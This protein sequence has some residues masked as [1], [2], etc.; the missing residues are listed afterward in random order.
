[1]RI[2]IVDDEK[3]QLKALDLGLRSS[4]FETET[5]GSAEEAMAVLDRRNHLVDLVVTD[6]VMPGVNGLQ[7]L[8]AIKKKYP[9]L[10]VVIMSAKGT[11]RLAKNAAE[12][13]GEKFMHKPFL[14][15]ELIREIR[16]ITG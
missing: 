11:D 3:D 15:E 2:L 8:R 6:F 9:F 14:M 12:S 10:P 4:G 1:M 7:L 13:G 5:A 16:K